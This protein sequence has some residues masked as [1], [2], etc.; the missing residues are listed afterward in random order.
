MPHFNAQR[1]KSKPL[2]PVLSDAK[3]TSEFVEIAQVY[4]DSV[5]FLYEITTTLFLELFLITL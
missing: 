2:E 3:A 1:R 5:L 4:K